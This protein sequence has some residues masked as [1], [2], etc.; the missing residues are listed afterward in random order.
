MVMNRSIQVRMTKD[1]YERIKLSS[2]LKGFSSLSSYLRYVALDQDFVV[3]QKVVELHKHLL[4]GQAGS[5]SPKTIA[6][7][8]H[9]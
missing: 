1:Q 6:A 8:R 2:K 4:G 9:I 7:G 5:N 3:H